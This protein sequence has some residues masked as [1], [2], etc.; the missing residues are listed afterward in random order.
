M[1]KEVEST[2]ENMI[3]KNNISKDESLMFHSYG[4]K[5]FNNVETAD[6]KLIVNN[7]LEFWV[8]D[9]LLTY[10]SDYFSYIFES[11]SQKDNFHNINLSLITTREENDIKTTRIT[12]PHDDLFFDV[13]LWIYSKDSKKLKKAAKTFQPF[14]YLLSLGIF[15]KMKEE[16]FEIL[17]SDLKFEWKIKSFENPLWSRSIFTFPILERIV[18]QMNGNTI[19]KITALLSWLKVINPETKLMLTDKDTIEE[20]TTSHDLFYVRNFIKKNKL[21]IT[22][23]TEEILQLKKSF[24]NFTTAFDSYG[25]INNFILGGKLMCLVCKKEFESQ[26]QINENTECKGK[27]DELRYHPR[28]LVKGGKILCGHDGC[29]RKFCKGEYSCCHKKL[30]N[31]DGCQLGDGRHIIVLVNNERCT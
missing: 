19:A 21:M 12:L 26:F 14:L 30:E 23:T 5:D 29:R 18:K 24:P 27:G 13:L 17:L 10:N 4:L 9:D 16:Y 1:D 11:Y 28:C 15:L 22:L 3:D 8:H 25:I 7:K 6:R 31:K 2:L 20:T